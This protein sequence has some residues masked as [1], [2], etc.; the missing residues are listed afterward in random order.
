MLDLGVVDRWYEAGKEAGGLIQFGVFDKRALLPLNLLSDSVKAETGED[1]TEADLLA[2]VE[3]GWFPLLKMEDPEGTLG[4]PLYVPSRVGLLLKLEREGYRPEELRLI[5]DFEEGTIDDLYSVDDMAYLDDDLD[6]LILMAEGR[7][8]AF[9]HVEPK[10]PERG[11]KIREE[12]AFLHNLKANGIPDRLKPVI[13]KHAFRARAW[14][15][16]MRIQ[17]MEMDRDKTRAGYSPTVSLSGHRWSPEERFTGKEVRWAS[18][19]RTS[20]AYVPEGGFPTIRIPG[21]LLCGDQVTPTKTL[22][23]AEY[24]ASWKANN[25]DEYLREWHQ[26]KGVRTCLHCMAPLLAGNE[27]KRFCGSRCRNAAKQK[28]FR[29]N[30]PMGA[31]RAQENYWAPEKAEK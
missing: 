22:R 26:L 4:W 15:E 11:D 12:L 7:L 18:T 3:A 17:L 13:E 9:E 31:L 27:R 10:D 29:E 6:T 28:R 23:P 2:K 20:L 24:T 25:L 16:G 5:A 8:D 14:N 1:I 21:W 30:N 19:L